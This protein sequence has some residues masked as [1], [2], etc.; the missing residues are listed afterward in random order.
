VPDTA[1]ARP[2]DPLDAARAPPL[3]ARCHVGRHAT[4]RQGCPRECQDNSRNGVQGMPTAASAGACSNRENRWQQEA[5][6]MAQCGPGRR[7]GS[8]NAIRVLLSAVCARVGPCRTPPPPRSKM[9]NRSENIDSEPR[10]RHHNTLDAHIFTCM[11]AAGP[12]CSAVLVLLSTAAICCCPAA[13]RLLLHRACVY[14]LLKHGSHLLCTTYGLSGCYL[15]PH[16]LR[17]AL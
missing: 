10:E 15:S 5:A 7:V 11:S 9:T 6:K 13:V 17:A 1:P 3:A 4:H 12:A 8:R 14:K 16:V 2:Q